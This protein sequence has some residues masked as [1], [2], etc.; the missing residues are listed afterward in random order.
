MG[1]EGERQEEKHWCAKRHINWL[2]LS[3]PQP[4]TWSTTQACALTGNHTSNPLVGRPALNPLSHTSQGWIIYFKRVNI[5]VC[6]WIISQFKKKQLVLHGLALMSLIAHPSYA[7]YLLLAL[8]SVAF[9]LLS[10]PHTV[11][12]LNCS[13]FMPFILSLHPLHSFSLGYLIVLQISV[14]DDTLT[15]SLPW[16][17]LDLDVPEAFH[18]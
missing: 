16:S 3:L 4:G 2:P 8:L 5:I 11:S 18:T 14:W 12:S 15:K 1:R 17:P 10:F 6:M 13:L 9:L 7:S